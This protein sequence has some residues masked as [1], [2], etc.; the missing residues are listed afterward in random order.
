MHCIRFE[1]GYVGFPRGSDNEESGMR[2]IWVQSL[3]WQDPLE[4]S[5]ALTPVFLPGEYSWTE[6]PGKLQS[7][8]LQRFGHN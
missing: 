4:E 1:V 5:M 2:E 6:V 3:G 8:G 7:M